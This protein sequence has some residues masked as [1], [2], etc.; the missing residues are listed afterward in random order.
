MTR[1][2]KG[3]ALLLITALL[4]ATPLLAQT[5]AQER[6]ALAQARADARAATAR[7]QRYEKE[8]T[9]AEGAAA[10]TRR[11]AAAIAARIQAAEADI[12]AARARIQLVDTLRARQRTRLATVQAP[13]VRMA[14]ALQTL[15]R[16][17]AALA[18]V[19]PGSIDDV[20]HV[21]ALLAAGVPAIRARAALV[22]TE[23]ARTEQL[24]LQGNRAAAALVASR[25]RLARERTALARVEAGHLARSA[26][27]VDTAMAEQDRALALGEEAR[28]IMTLMEEIDIRAARRDRLAALPGPIP[29]PLVPGLAAVPVPELTAANRPP[30][31]RLPVVGRVLTG[32]GEVSD[33]GIRARGVTLSPAASAQVVSPGA[34]RIAYAGGFRGYGR[35]VIVDHGGG[36]TTLLTGLGRTAVIAGQTVDAGSPLGTAATTRPSITVELRHDGRP[37]DIAPLLAG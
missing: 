11:A 8:A 12:A 10:R 15:A 30:P 16:R 35:I 21:R 9:Q 26:S 13:I 31:Y 27:L 5:V 32:L 23:L 29:R 20:V 14:V 28:D 1:H 24:R 4:V 37:V 36:W 22:R 6:K 33:A 2:P 17:P 7:A 25:D 3:P 19:Q 18:L 34:G